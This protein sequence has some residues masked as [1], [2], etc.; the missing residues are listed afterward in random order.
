MDTPPVWVLIAIAIVAIIIIIA[1]IM[2]RRPS[3]KMDFTGLVIVRADGTFINVQVPPSPNE[4][5]AP[6]FNYNPQDIA[7]FVPPGMKIMFYSD[8]LHR[9]SIP[10]MQ[11]S[12]SKQPLP[13]AYWGYRL[14]TPN[15]TLMQTLA[16]GSLPPGPNINEP[17]SAPVAP[18][19]PAP[20]VN[21]TSAP[22]SVPTDIPT[23]FNML[24]GSTMAAA[25]QPA[26]T[27]DAAGAIKIDNVASIIVP[28]GTQVA[29]Y[30]DRFPVDIPALQSSPAP[31]TIP[32]GA[33]A[34]KVLTLSAK[35]TL[36]S[37]VP[38]YVPPPDAPVRF[39]IAATDGSITP[40]TAPPAYSFSE[41]ACHPIP[42][43]TL[44]INAPGA[45][46]IFFQDQ[47][48]LPTTPLKPTSREQPIPAGATCFRIKSFRRA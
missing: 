22:A 10:P 3:R 43:N 29:L 4:S 6:V 41:G 47:T 2:F 5:T 45:Q 25:L 13:S 20:L 32:L 35:R 18:I 21:P 31:Q 28:E 46:V 30:S 1:F 7:L 8:P 39:V 12:S 33:T 42:P 36:M 26:D 27:E 16:D 23:V 48:P 14:L 44:G 40:S 37:P 17:S 24:D 19:A 15:A 9:D 34:I 11:S 38:L